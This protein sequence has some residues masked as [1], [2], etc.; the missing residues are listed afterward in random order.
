MLKYSD[1]VRKIEG[2]PKERGYIALKIDF[3]GELDDV[4]EVYVP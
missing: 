2:S 4:S 1:E 3:T